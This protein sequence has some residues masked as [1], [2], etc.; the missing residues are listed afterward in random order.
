[1][2][3]TESA[4]ALTYKSNTA[5]LGGKVCL[6]SNAVVFEIPVGEEK[7]DEKYYKAYKKR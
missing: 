1:M 4:E 7:A 5:I 2:P 6:A 3:D